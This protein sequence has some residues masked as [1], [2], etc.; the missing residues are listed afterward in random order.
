MKGT[1]T[2]E[3]KFSGSSQKTRLTGKNAVIN[4]AQ[5]MKP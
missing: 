5:G 2:A 1:K 3:M 4:I